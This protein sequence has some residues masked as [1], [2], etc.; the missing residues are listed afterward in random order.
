MPSFP[1][2]I[3]TQ[4]CCEEGWG[5]ERT[6]DSQTSPA[7]FLKFFSAIPSQSQ[8]ARQTRAITHSDWRE[9]GKRLFSRVVSIALHGRLKQKHGLPSTTCLHQWGETFSCSRAE[10]C[11]LPA[12]QLFIPQLNSPGCF[13][14]R[15]QG[16]TLKS[17]SRL[18]PLKPR[19]FGIEE[20]THL[21][22]TTSLSLQPKTRSKTLIRMRP[23]VHAV[24]THPTYTS[25]HSK[26]ESTAQGSSD[27]LMQ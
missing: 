13:G 12:S 14:Q 24:E 22:G 7:S 25:S 10:D 19:S 1:R 9:L 11:M 21:F 15:K 4:A 18:F 3:Q 20:T 6:S 2:R 27:Q 17:P 5:E 23:P 8:W 16:R 26:T